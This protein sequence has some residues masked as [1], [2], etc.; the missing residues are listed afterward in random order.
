MDANKQGEEKLPKTKQDKNKT[1]GNDQKRGMNPGIIGG[2][3]TNEQTS[4]TFELPILERRLSYRALL[5]KLAVLSISS[6][7]TKSNLSR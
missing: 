4:I 7:E 6:L 3:R 2:R 1:K 5:V